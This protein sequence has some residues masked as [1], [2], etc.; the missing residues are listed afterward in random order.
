[1]GAYLLSLQEQSNQPDPLFRRLIFILICFSSGNSNWDLPSR[2][3]NLGFSS[4]NLRAIATINLPPWGPYNRLERHLEVKFSLGLVLTFGL[5]STRNTAPRV[6]LCR[7]TGP[8]FASSI[9]NFILR[10]G[11]APIVL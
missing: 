11:L 10:S 9:S 4:I 2:G 5:Y 8:R 1:M 7:T 6:Q 3:H